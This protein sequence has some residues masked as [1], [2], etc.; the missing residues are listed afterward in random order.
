MIIRRVTC[1][2]EMGVSAVIAVVMWKEAIEEYHRNKKINTF[3][4]EGFTQSEQLNNRDRVETLKK[5][6][7]T[8]AP[9][10]TKT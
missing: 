7:T 8:S 4:F 1:H 5:I 10:E 2:M 9:N 6:M 3:E